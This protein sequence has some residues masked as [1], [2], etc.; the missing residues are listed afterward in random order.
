MIDL[1]GPVGGFIS[2]ALV[3]TIGSIWFAYVLKG[4][5]QMAPAPRAIVYGAIW[6]AYFV[7]MTVLIDR[8]QA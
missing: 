4:L 8:L 1:S 3:A 5:K 2:A 6:L 7:L